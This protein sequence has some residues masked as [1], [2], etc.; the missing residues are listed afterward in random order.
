M[1]NVLKSLLEQRHLQAH[2][3]FVAEYNRCAHELNLARRPEPPTKAQYYRWI[4]G[5]VKNLPRPHHCAV[6]E[7]MFP[8]WEA[9][10]LFGP[11]FPEL[12]AR[13]GPAQADDELLSD[14]APGLDPNLL[15]GLWASCYIL[16]GTR[17]HV[18]LSTVVA[19][20]YG[21]TSIN[22]PPEPRAEGHATGHITDISARLFGRYLMGHWKNRND[23]YYFGSVHLTVLPAENVLDG[24]YTG[25]LHDSHVVSERWRWVRIDPESARGVDLASLQ[26]SDPDRVHDIVMGHAQAGGPVSLAS[27]TDRLAEL[28]K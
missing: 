10:E 13:H 22:Y 28:R 9:K 23:H 24:Y 5:N 25:F 19:T 26:L 27:V 2:S 7:R 21:M 3:D 12:T 16:E 20:K 18:D 15:S 4:G 17:R 6:L 1:G 11:S 8:G 14:I